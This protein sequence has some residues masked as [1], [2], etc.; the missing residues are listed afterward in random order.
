MNFRRIFLVKCLLLLFPS[1]KCSST[2][3]IYK[4]VNE[5]ALLSI[6]APG[7]IYEATWTKGGQRLVQI[8]NDRTRHYVNKDQCRCAMLRNGTLQIQRLEKADSGNYTVLV[9]QQDGRL[10]AEENIMFFVQEPVPQPILNAECRNKSVSVKCEVKQKAK[11]EA[12]LIELTQPTGKKIQKNATTLEWHGR[13]SGMFRC[14]VKN[15][16]SEKMTEKVIKCPG[17]LDFYLILSI[18]GGAVFFVILVICLI[19][20]IRRKKTKR[21]ED[22]EEERVM[23]TLPMDREKGMRELPQTPSTPT[24]RQLRVQQ[25]PLPQ[26][27]GPQQALPPQP[28]PQPRP[29]PRTQPRTP[30][31]PRER[32]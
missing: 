4:A 13:N 15:Q 17:K 14:V 28:R 30:N 32:P 3:L 22:Y 23:Q 8:K 6:T 2:S 10:K 31:L 24:P 19:Y 21:H 11:D 7:S 25:R 29:R 1:V 26:P 5:T 9:Y 20:C 27:H 16:V 12:F 18:A